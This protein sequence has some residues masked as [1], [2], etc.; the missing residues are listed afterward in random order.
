MGRASRRCAPTASARGLDNMVFHPPRPWRELPESLAAADVHLVTMWER[1]SGLVVPSKF[2]G[3]LAVGRPCL[4]A[5]PA[6][7]EVARTITERDCGTVVGEE[8][9]PALAAALEAARERS[10]APLLPSGE[11]LPGG[12]RFHVARG[13]RPPGARVGR[14]RR[15]SLAWNPATR[16]APS[17]MSQAIDA[18]PS[19]NAPVASDSRAGLALGGLAG[20]VASQRWLAGGLLVLLDLACFYAVHRALVALNFNEFLAGA[21][22][23]L[24]VVPVI[25]TVSALLVIGGYDPRNPLRGVAYLSEHILAV[26]A[27]RGALGAGGLC[28]D[29]VWGAH[30]AASLRAR[31]HLRGLHP[32]LAAGPRAAHASPGGAP[33]AQDFPCPRRGAGGA[34]VLQRPIRP[35]RTHSASSSLIRWSAASAN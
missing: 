2:Y 16:S 19:P 9:A 7:S 24:F 1:L 35:S 3:V 23:P 5:G 29:L 15:L 20:A 6:G 25:V 11:R 28:G 27:R 34:D 33:L 22:V 8:D 13:G 26:L 17:H 14:K 32:L 10:D 30:P 31:G 21:F 18:K 4:F 12:G